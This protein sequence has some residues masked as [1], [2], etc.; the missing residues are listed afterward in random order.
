L[1]FLRQS[2][3]QSGAAM[4]CD[5]TNSATGAAHAVARNWRRAQESDDTP[6]T[7]ITRRIVLMV[8]FEVN[9]GNKSVLY[10]STSFELF[11]RH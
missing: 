10:G 11:N 8:M 1:Q 5:G 7:K 9:G 6:E 4:A 3:I 2:V